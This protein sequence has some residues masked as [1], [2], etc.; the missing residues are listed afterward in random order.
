MPRPQKL[1]M[2]IV[3]SFVLEY[4]Q[5]ILLREIAQAKGISLSDLMREIIEEYLSKHGLIEKKAVAR[6]AGIQQ[7]INGVIA[8]IDNIEFDE[9]LGILKRELELMR[10][11][12]PKSPMWINAN[13]RARKALN[14]IKALIAKGSILSKKKIDEAIRLIH[15][16][17][18]MTS[19]EEV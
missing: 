9:A 5:F 15:E 2:P 17:E 14:K 19:S 11:S 18:K 3:K 12:I 8:K 13:F 6:D 4:E 7:A 10:K 1:N 16:Y